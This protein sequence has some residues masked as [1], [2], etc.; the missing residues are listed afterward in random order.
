MS[1]A[2]IPHLGS[3]PTTTPV[4][5]LKCVLKRMQH[6]LTTVVDRV[7]HNAHQIHYHMLIVQ[8]EHVSVRVQPCQLF[9]EST[10]AEFVL[11]I[12]LMAVLLIIPQDCVLLT[13]IL[14]IRRHMEITRPGRVLLNVQPNL[15]SLQTS[16]HT[17]V[18]ISVRVTPMPTTQPGSVYF[19]VMT[20]PH[21][22]TSRLRSA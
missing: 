12:V 19:H 5:V 21:L 11:H 8:Q 2:A 4:D 17:F 22:Q 1:L 18:S 3:L 6:L 10:A 14:P 20:Q 9:L 13:V 7:F 15:G 16:R